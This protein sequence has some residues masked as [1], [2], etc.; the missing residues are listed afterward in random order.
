MEEEEEALIQDNAKT[1]DRELA[2]TSRQLELAVRDIFNGGDETLTLV[3]NEDGNGNVNN[4]NAGGDGK[5]DNLAKGDAG[6]ANEK[7][8]ENDVGHG[9]ENGEGNG[10]VIKDNEKIREEE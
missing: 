9:S 10:E 8:S 5:D 4:V 6:E 3:E 1:Q 2:E 7:G